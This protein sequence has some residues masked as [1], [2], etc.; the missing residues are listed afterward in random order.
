M[1]TCKLRGIGYVPVKKLEAS[2]SSYQPR[3]LLEHLQH[4][5]HVLTSSE[6]SQVRSEAKGVCTRLAGDMASGNTEVVAT[7]IAYPNERM[8][9][10]PS[11][12][13]P[14]NYGEHPVMV[15]GFR[16]DGPTIRKGTRKVLKDFPRSCKY[17]DKPI[18]Q[19]GLQRESYVY[20]NSDFHFEHGVRVVLRG[21]WDNRHQNEGDH[22]IFACY[23]PSSELSGLSTRIVFKQP[24]Y[25]EKFES[26]MS[27]RRVFK[28]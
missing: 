10:S 14:I 11:F 6:W 8:E 20:A 17:L 23:G 9:Y 15:E 13:P 19:L 4:K 18:E 3:R 24:H 5:I 2:A 16:I 1:E 21:G 27:N 22:R 25:S 26:T 12:D 7:L 28:F